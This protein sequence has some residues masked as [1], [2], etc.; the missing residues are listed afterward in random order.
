MFW[1]G[2]DTGEDQT[3]KND[4]QIEKS[5]P[6]ETFQPAEIFVEPHTG[7]LSI[8]KSNAINYF[9]RLISTL[10]AKIKFCVEQKQQKI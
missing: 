2:Y 5:Q 4:Q 8:M 3:M 7:K 6:N 10:P 1:S 9:Y